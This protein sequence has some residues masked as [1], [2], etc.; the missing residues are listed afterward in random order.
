LAL[1]I[2]AQN[3][4]LLIRKQDTRTV[5]EVFEVETPTTEVTSCSGKLLRVFPGPAVEVP[6]TVAHN[7]GF[8]EQLSDMLCQLDVESMDDARTAP[9]K[10]SRGVREVPEPAHPKYISQL[11]VGI[12]RGQGTDAEVARIR[13]R[14]A[15]EVLFHKD[16]F[17]PW[18]RSPTWLVIRVAL[19]TSLATNFEY[20]SFMVYLLARLLKFCAQQELDS[21][22]V[23][24]MRAKMARR[25]HKLRAH[26]S[27]SGPAADENDNVIVVDDTDSGS[28]IEFVGTRR[29][30]STPLPDFVL[31]TV[32]EAAEYAGKLLQ[33]RWTDVE[34][35]QRESADWDPD[36]LDLPADTSLSLAN[37]HAYLQLLMKPENGH[38]Q[39][40]AF[41]PAKVSRIR[42]DNF[43]AY[44][45]G[46]LA[47]AY[48][49]CGRLALRDFEEAVL[50]YMDPWIQNRI[51]EENA[52]ESGCRTL[53]ACCEEYRTLFN[54]AYAEPDVS[55]MSIAILTT[56]DVWH[57][58]DRLAVKQFQHVGF[59]GEYSPEI[60]INF[61][62]PLLLR[63]R[64]HLERSIKLENYIRR[65][66]GHHGGRKIDVSI[67][68]DTRD[69]DSFSNRYYTATAALQQKRVEIEADATRKR[70]EKRAELREANA[71]YRALQQRVAAMVCERRSFSHGVQ[72]HRPG[73]CPKCK[74]L[75]RLRSMRILVHEWPL[76]SDELE[77]QAVV[78]ELSVPSIFGIWRSITYLVVSDLGLPDRV[79][80]HS[81]P[82]ATLHGYTGLKDHARLQSGSRITFAAPS[83][84]NENN[85][86]ALPAAESEVFV[87]HGMQYRLFDKT[88]NCW[89]AG[90][91]HSA[92]VT[93]HGTLQIEERSPYRY[94]QYA[95][96]KTDHP[97][98]QVLA[99]QSDCPATLSIHEH[100]A[101]GTL[102]SGPLLQWPNILRELASPNLS[103]RREE[104]YTL[105]TQ[106]A[107]QIGPLYNSS[108]RIWHDSLQDD[109]Y[110]QSLLDVCRT[111]LLNVR[112]NWTEGGTVKLLG[113]ALA[114][115]LSPFC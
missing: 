52:R 20:K 15:D 11:L 29:T 91:F 115:T 26:I 70:E 89:A 73:T 68:S 72:V 98:N 28:E 44:A 85:S 69:D 16:A 6:G 84:G 37:S 102:R 64:L 4:A 86:V 92:N 48:A 42:A 14:V 31:R 39:P 13:K 100:Q 12:L 96:E 49:A 80:H 40:A 94:L 30:E 34:D 56:V 81:R 10:T 71:T 23:F 8:L 19:Q 90:P 24:L 97:P 17:V 77:V 75:K 57:G 45:N 9:V 63:S 47:T 55:E 43:E 101:F 50:R 114:R 35:Q 59:L 83:K 1:H 25:L 107:W 78:F 66:H 67:F 27:T 21:E 99:D 54:K 41:E 18:R 51:S 82:G 32:Q 79:K 113:T 74:E 2:R 108:A 93:E 88:T 109:G 95:V 61:L 5:F 58:V 33:T 3:A 106:A 103:L 38:A 7:H 46:A 36:S 22:I 76:P 104:V 60:P 53:W 110:G 62:D 105:V 112:A 65:R 111:L 87:A